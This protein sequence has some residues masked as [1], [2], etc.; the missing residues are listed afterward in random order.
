[1][2]KAKK[3]SRSESTASFYAVTVFCAVI[4]GYPVLSVLMMFLGVEGGGT[5]NVGYRAVV[6]LLSCFTIFY[7]L[8]SRSGGYGERID[9]W[10]VLFFFIYGVRLVY[11]WLFVGSTEAPVAVAFYFGVVLLPIH[12]VLISP[13]W[14]YDQ[15]KLALWCG[16]LA[17]FVNLCVT[18]LVS[19]G[20]QL[21]I[22]TYDLDTARVGFETLNPITIGTTAGITLASFI[23]LANVTGRSR[24]FYFYAWFGIAIGTYTLIIANSRGPLLATALTIGVYLLFK[25]RNFWKFA[26]VVLVLALPLALNGEGINRITNRFDSALLLDAS[27]DQRRVVQDAAWES[28]IT[29]PILGEH[30]IDQSIVD[31]PAFGPG[32]YPHNILLEAGMATGLLGF[33][34]F[35]SFILRSL[36]R[37]A[38]GYGKRFPYFSLLLSMSLLMSFSSGSIA[39]ADSLFLLLLLCLGA[40]MPPLSATRMRS[41]YHAPVGGGYPITRPS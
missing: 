23:Y 30:F 32:S 34:L 40:K 11:D 20:F 27:V 10:L 1:M 41:R 9:K 8:T 31:N 25:I 37:I 26:P 15:E 7:S 33:L 21:D 5:I 16:S 3:I 28:F 29:H 2:D 22:Y 39:F 18:L 36:L 17:L 4:I 14:N 35:L 12:A 19:L 6:L 38:R 13:L 24:L